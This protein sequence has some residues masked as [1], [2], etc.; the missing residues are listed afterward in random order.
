MKDTAKRKK[1]ATRRPSCF[2]SDSWFSMPLLD[3]FKPPLSNR[4]H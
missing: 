1:L 3:H 2:F 4:R